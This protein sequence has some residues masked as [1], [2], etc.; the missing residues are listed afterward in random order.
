MDNGKGKMPTD[1]SHSDVSAHSLES[2]FG[3]LIMRTP[4][5][6]RVLRNEERE[7]LRCSG[8]SVS[9]CVCVC[10]RNTRQRVRERER[11]RAKNQ[12]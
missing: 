3:V 7:W 1:D 9:V 12:S 8:Y 6:K 2:E 5:V 10:A 4:D 11:E